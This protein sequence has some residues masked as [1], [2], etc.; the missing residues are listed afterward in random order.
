ML[1]DLNPQY[2]CVPDF[3]ARQSVTRRFSDEQRIVWNFVPAHTQQFCFF[4]RPS[5]ELAV[6]GG[7][8]STRQ[9]IQRHLYEHWAKRVDALFSRVNTYTLDVWELVHFAYRNV[10]QRILLNMPYLV[11]YGQIHLTE[12]LHTIGILQL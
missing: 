1:W 4:R 12:W 11:E 3:D 2:L 10:K 9:L 8:T 6:P 7:L 5:L